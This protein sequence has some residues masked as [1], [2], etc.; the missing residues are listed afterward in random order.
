M[1]SD[2]CATRRTGERAGGGRQAQVELFGQVDVRKLEAGLEEVVGCE[3]LRDVRAHC[4]LLIRHSQ[5]HRVHAVAVVADALRAAVLKLAVS[6]EHK[7]A[8]RS[9][10]LLTPTRLPCRCPLRLRL[11]LFHVLYTVRRCA[12]GRKTRHSICV[13][14]RASGARE[15]T[16]RVFVRLRLRV[17]RYEWVRTLRT[18]SKAT[19]TQMSCARVMNATP[20]ITPT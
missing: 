13:E 10:C 1:Q 7:T 17:D 4:A 12:I 14:P 11:L 15:N 2:G 6:A 3:A 5:A 9:C 18:A 19:G 16:V 8:Q 20:T